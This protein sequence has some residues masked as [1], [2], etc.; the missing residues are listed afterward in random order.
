MRGKERKLVTQEEA[1][2][3]DWGARMRDSVKSEAVTVGDQMEA[4][5]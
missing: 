1:S 5:A 2:E 3:T 4:E